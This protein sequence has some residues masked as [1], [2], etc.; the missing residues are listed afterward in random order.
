MVKVYY[1]YEFSQPYAQ[2]ISKSSNFLYYHPSNHTLIPEKLFITG[3]NQY[4]AIIS[5][6]SG[7][8]QKYLFKKDKNIAV[9][10]VKVSGGKIY[11]GYEDG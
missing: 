5:S 1:S 10:C 3:V 4:I 7:E 9:R 11:A 2:I 6:K 8:V